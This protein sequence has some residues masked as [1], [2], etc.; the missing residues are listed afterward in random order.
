VCA[1]DNNGEKWNIMWLMKLWTLREEEVYLSTEIR[2]REGDI[3][4]WLQKR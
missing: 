1:W 4:L 2:G 3:Q